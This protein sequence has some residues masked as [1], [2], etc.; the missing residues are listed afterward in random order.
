MNK[1]HSWCTNIQMPYNAFIFWLTAFVSPPTKSNYNTLPANWVPA[2]NSLHT[3]Q[4]RTER[5]KEQKSE[6][7][8]RKVRMRRNR[9]VR[10]KGESR[11][12]R[13]R[14]QR[15]S[16]NHFTQQALKV[17]SRGKWFAEICETIESI[18]HTEAKMT[19]LSAQHL[20]LKKSASLVMYWIFWS[21]VQSEVRKV[22]R[23]SLFP[24]YFMTLATY[25][26]WICY[27][28]CKHTTTTNIVY[29]YDNFWGT[30]WTFGLFIWG[31]DATH[32]H[33]LINFLR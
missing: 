4:E 23:I 18:L 15:K 10:G 27:S 31:K 6:S 3:T 30:S 25:H 8:G 2:E 17:C 7:W 21:G 16:L 1:V 33:T 13:G 12:Q 26:T 9:W 20:C 32:C 5:V 14:T 24:F 29:G 11:R 22:I 19:N 28:I